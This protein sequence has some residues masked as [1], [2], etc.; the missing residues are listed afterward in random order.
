MKNMRAQGI[1]VQIGSYALHAHPAFQSATCR[2]HGNYTGSKAAF[3]Q[4]L[5]LPIY[6]GMT[7]DE[8]K[9]VVNMLI[10]NV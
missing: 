1:E 10:K 3:D 7:Q 8:Q 6:H 4:S 5:A 9:A 2:L